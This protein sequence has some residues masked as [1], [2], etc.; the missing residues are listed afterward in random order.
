[1]STT[2]RCPSR[3]ATSSRCATSLKK[4]DPQT[5][6]YFLLTTH[7]RSPSTSSDVS[8]KETEGRVKYLYETWRALTRRWGRDRAIRRTE[9]IGWR[10]FLP[11]FQE[12]MDDDF[13]T[14]KALGDF[15]EVFTLANDILQKP[16]D[17]GID[18]RTLRAAPGR[19]NRRGL[20]AR[21]FS[22]SRPRVVLSRMASRRQADSGIDP[23]EIDKLVNERTQARKART[24]GAPMRSA[25]SSQPR[26]SSSRTR[27]PVP[28]GSL[29]ECPRATAKV[30]LDSYRIGRADI[31]GRA[32]ALLF[33]LVLT[34]K[35]A[36]ADA[37]E[38]T[39]GLGVVAQAPQA[40]GG[41]L[42]A[43]YGIGDFLA[44]DARF[45]GGTTMKNGLGYAEAGLVALF[46]VVTWVPELRLGFGAEVLERETSPLVHAAAAL[47]A[48][49]DADLSAAA[50]SRRPVDAGRLAGTLVLSLWLGF[51]SFPGLGART[52]HSDIPCNLLVACVLG[53][54]L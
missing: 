50:R 48:L 28:P 30:D 6:R 22:R 24:S 7:Y 12:A 49:P 38:V 29:A 42:G 21:R 26:V 39:V 32:V 3:S 34:P 14:A 15:S 46:D 9:W 27:R 47:R 5:L 54:T 52:P 20:C 53:V 25:R 31:T 35:A 4:F 11:R 16:Q 19:D 17:P 40:F 43:R 13:N 2:R 23:A 45:G 18:G 44:L 36:R 33:V 37:G 10:R 8:L 1:M 51:S 41:E